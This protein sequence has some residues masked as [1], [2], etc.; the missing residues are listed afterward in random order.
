[1]ATNSVN[2]CDLDSMKDLNSTELEILKTGTNVRFG[3]V[4]MST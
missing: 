3:H 1:M 2:L 4:F